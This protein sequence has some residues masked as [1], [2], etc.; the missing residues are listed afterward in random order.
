V[1]VLL[2]E[3]FTD[4]YGAAAAPLKKLYLDIEKVYSEPTFRPKTRRVKATS[5]EAAWDCLGTAE[6]MAGYAKLMD[7]AK[8]LATT[9]REK[10]NV[11]L[12]DLSIWK[13]MTVGRAQYVARTSAPIPSIEAAAV[14]DA[15][16]EPV[17]VAWERA[18]ELSGWFDRGTST[19]AP[20]KLSGR[21][22]HDG[23]YLYVEL[24]DPCETAKLVASPG[25]ACYDDWEIFT[26][27][28]RGLPYRQFLVGPTG[29]VKTLLNG[30]VN[31][32]MYVPHPEHGVKVASD[33]SAPNK[34]IERVSIPLK[35]VVPGGA[36]PGDTIYLNVVRVAGPA[37]TGTGLGIST[38]VP[39]TTVHDL[40]RLAEVKLGK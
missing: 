9:E 32:R 22:A 2:D 23:Q 12:F 34:W 7:E 28:Q 14:P 6:R 35:E 25:V 10:R 38:W 15:G 40:D 37:V 16:G 30:E 1:D 5:V 26:A 39:H 29:M 21:I 11:E 36:K 20:R 17:K 19:P 3:Y 4:L 31:W 18:T 13:Y 8:A 24:V 27:K 33:T